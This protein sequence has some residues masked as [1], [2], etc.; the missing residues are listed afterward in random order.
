MNLVSWRMGKIHSLLS[1]IQ[2]VLTY[3]PITNAD[4]YSFG[5]KLL[6]SINSNILKI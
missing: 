4:K 1:S 6:P 3:I 2:S 5:S